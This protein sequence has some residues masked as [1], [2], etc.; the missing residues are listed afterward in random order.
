M[1]ESRLQQEDGAQER[2][3]GAE[4]ICKARVRQRAR[5]A[6]LVSETATTKG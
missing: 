2:Q 1:V 6:S 3:E 4:P 5:I